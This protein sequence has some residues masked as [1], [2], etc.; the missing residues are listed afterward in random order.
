MPINLA[1]PEYQRP[2]VVRDEIA[3]MVFRCKDCEAVVSVPSLNPAAPI[4]SESKSSASEASAPNG[5]LSRRT[6]RPKRIGDMTDGRLINSRIL[7]LPHD[8]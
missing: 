8:A 1:C 7:L 4:S 3:G 5:R 2:F 6:L